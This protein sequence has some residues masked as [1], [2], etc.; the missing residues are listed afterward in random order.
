MQRETFGQNLTVIT[1]EWPPF[2]YTDKNGQIVGYSVELV[3][4]AIEQA[5][6][7]YDLV[8]MPW[9]RG[10]HLALKKPSTAIFTT[11]R[12][13]QR[14]PLFKWVGPLYSKQTILFRLKS[15]N[16]IIIKSLEDARHYKIGVVRG[17]ANEEYLKANGFT[18]ELD[19][20]STDAQNIEKFFNRRFDL[21]P[22]DALTTLNMKNMPYNFSDLEAAFV[23]IEGVE[24]SI[25][26]N[27]DTPGDMINRIQAGLDAV[28]EKKLKETLSIK[29]LQ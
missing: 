16:D 20:A 12:S 28:V 27:K 10:Y 25:A 26:F 18:S 13:A 6:I 21:L 8:M 24:Y 14:E 29:Y 17:G 2:N 3:K 7:K 5:G 22:G 19:A 23:L 4:A 11:T 15:R 9:A 1:E